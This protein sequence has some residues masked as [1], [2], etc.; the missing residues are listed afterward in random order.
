[1]YHIVAEN[2]LNK[3][4]LLCLQIGTTIFISSAIVFRKNQVK[5][6]SA[7]VTTDIHTRV[8]CNSGWGQL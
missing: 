7:I 3:Q 1:M 8:G 2:I 4:V 5:K 6:K